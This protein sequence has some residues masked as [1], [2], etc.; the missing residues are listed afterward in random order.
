MNKP[1]TNQ[2]VDSLKLYRLVV[3]KELR[4]ARK[5]ACYTG[6]PE[7]RAFCIGRLKVLEKEVLPEIDKLL[8]DLMKES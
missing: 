3:I 2:L 1:D 4:L 6:N 5:N 7:Y 8:A